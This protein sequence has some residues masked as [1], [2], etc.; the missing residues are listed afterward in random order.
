MPR[1]Q[2]QGGWIALSPR[3]R[4]EMHHTRGALD[5]G[6]YGT[7]V[8][9]RRDR[10]SDNRPQNRGRISAQEQSDH[11]RRIPPPNSTVSLSHLYL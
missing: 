10:V 9:G 8:Q 3:S 2:G 5:S 4:K 6:A 7:L 11:P 1:M